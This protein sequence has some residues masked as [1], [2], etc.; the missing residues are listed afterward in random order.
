MKRILMLFMVAVLPAA[1]QSEPQ[2]LTGFFGVGFAEAVNPLAE[3]LDAGWSLSGGIG[4]R[5]KYVG[6]LFDAMFTDFGINHRT[7]LEAGIPRGDQKYWAVTVDPIVHVNPHGPVD[8]YIT[9]GGGI[10]S[11]ITDYRAEYGYGGYWGYGYRN[12]LIASYTL[13]KPGVDGGAGLAFSIG[14]H[15]RAK[16]F[17][18]AR[19]HHMF[20]QG[21]RASFI[22]VTLGVQF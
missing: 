20:T 5:Q 9:G 17:A 7:L 2:R 3:N 6:V 18:E 10:Y 15:S 16:F 22:P 8:F 1:A 21:S 13:Y 4:V 11:Q 12:Y 14:E 19:F